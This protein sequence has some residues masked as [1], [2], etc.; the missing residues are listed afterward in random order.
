MYKNL[1]KQILSI[2]MLDLY[3]NFKDT[4]STKK[5][6]D[7]NNVYD[8]GP[9]L[10]NS[11]LNN[12][13]RISVRPL[14][15]SSMTF[16]INIHLNESQLTP[17]CLK[18][19]VDAG[20]DILV[21]RINND[22]NITGTRY[23]KTHSYKNRY[24]FPND[25]ILFPFELEEHLK[26]N[27]G[28]NNLVNVDGSSWGSLAPYYITCEYMP[29]SARV[30]IAFPT[31][32]MTE[33][34]Q[35]I[36]SYCVPGWSLITIFHPSPYIDIMKDIKFITHHISSIYSNSTSNETES[37]IDDNIL[38]VHSNVGVGQIQRY[39]DLYTAMET[40][41]NRSGQIEGCI[42]IKSLR[43][44]LEAHARELNIVLISRE[45]EQMICD[46]K[47]IKNDKQYNNNNDNN[48]HRANKTQIDKSGSM[49]KNIV[50]RL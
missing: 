39:Y 11:Q 17:P 35:N 14:L 48:K 44:K 33:F 22:G 20:Y 4:K 10:I 6:L 37:I 15:L 26:Y 49:K 34:L 21:H 12:T 50:R 23:P 36:S 24:S 25:E 42:I 16:S 27:F 31:T 40:M 38:S 9:K 5:S 30:F 7:L 43:V 41:L 18:G 19:I 13:K 29:K 2:Y 1:G 46:D 3:K 45:C 28:Y 8:T 32:F 47:K